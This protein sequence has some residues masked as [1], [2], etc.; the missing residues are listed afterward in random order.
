MNCGTLMTSPG[1]TVA[2][3]TRKKA[4]RERFMLGE[5]VGQSLPE[6]SGRG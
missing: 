3:S 6:I 1:W 4:R 2:A 5:R